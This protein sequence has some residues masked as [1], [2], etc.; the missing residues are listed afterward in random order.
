MTNAQALLYLIGALVVFAVGSYCFYRFMVY[1]F[2]KMD[3][4]R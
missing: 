3:N 2:T 4:K 1:I